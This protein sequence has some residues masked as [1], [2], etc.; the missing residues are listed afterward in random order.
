MMNSK[1]KHQAKTSVRLPLIS[2]KPFI[3]L[4]STQQVPKV[5]LAHEMN[6]LPG[7]GCEII[8]LQ[9][10][11]QDIDARKAVFTQVFCLYSIKRYLYLEVKWRKSHTCATGA[12]P[13]LCVPVGPDKRRKSPPT[14]PRAHKD[15][16]AGLTQRAWRVGVTLPLAAGYTV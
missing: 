11:G 6:V 2:F 10:E 5:Y 9:K 15:L 1:T 14:H 12:S 8:A 16:R 4:P 7:T 3:I 13:Q